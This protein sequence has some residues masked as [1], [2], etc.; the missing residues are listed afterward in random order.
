MTQSVENHRLTRAELAAEIERRKPWYQ[1]IEFPEY[2]ITTTDDPANAMIDAAWDNKIGDLTL[3]QAA[4]MRPQP[5]WAEIRKA[6]PNVSGLDVLE[7]GSNCGYFSFEFVKAGA[8]SVVGLDVSDHWL[9]NAR[10]A[11]SVLGYRNID[12]RNVDFMNYSAGEQRDA[13]GLLSDESTSI[14]LP[15]RKFDV[16]FMSTVI[17]HLFFPLFSIYKMLRIA[18]KH[19]VID[20]PVT[21]FDVVADKKA[22]TLDVAP[23]GSHHGFLADPRFWRTYVSRLGVPDERIHQHL[24]NDDHGMCMVIDCEGRKPALWGA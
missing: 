9:N 16:V 10:W 18:R 17:D 21:H 11:A 1:R 23:D 19:V 2:S 24:Y 12:F 20:C 5:K 22:L 7:I 13:E 3:E 8:R 15:N 4:I 6:L 14:P